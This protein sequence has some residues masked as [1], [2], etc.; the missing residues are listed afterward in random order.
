MNADTATRRTDA[1]PARESSLIAADELAAKAARAVGCRASVSRRRRARRPTRRFASSTSSSPGHRTGES[2]SSCASTPDRPSV[3]SLGH[4]S[5]PA[6]RFEREMHDLFGIVP[7]GHPFLRPLV[8]HQ[9]W[10]EG[11]HPMLPR[12]R[13]ATTDADRRGPVPVRTGR[14]ARRL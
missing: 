2:S 14:G 13:A 9:H 3:P 10:P 7:D 12:R 8:L 6:S 5:F 4:L 1:S 11:W